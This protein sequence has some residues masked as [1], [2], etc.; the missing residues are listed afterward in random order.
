MPVDKNDGKLKRFC[1][2]ESISTSIWGTIK[3]N[4]VKF[5]NQY[6]SIEE[7]RTSRQTQGYNRFNMN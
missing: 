6:I 4:G 3:L 1:I 5:R 7:T 2:V